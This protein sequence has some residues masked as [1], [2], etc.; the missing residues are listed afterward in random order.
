[1]EVLLGGLA[2]RPTFRLV[3]DGSTLPVSSYTHQVRVGGVALDEVGDLTQIVDLVA[4]GATVVMQSLQRT[5]PPL[6]D[7][8]RDLEVAIG[9]PVQANAYLSPGIG[10]GGLGQHAD[11][12]DVIVLQIAGSKAWDVEGLGPLVLEPGDVLYLPAGTSHHARAESG[13]SLH[14]TIGI[15]CVTRRQVLRRIVDDLGDEFDQPLPFGF[16][17]DEYLLVGALSE[18]T[19]A[20][21]RALADVDVG[22]LATREANRATHRRRRPSGGRLRTLVDEAALG[23]DVVLRRRCAVDITELDDDRLEVRFGGRRLQMPASAR[24]AMD[25]VCSRLTLRVDELDGLDQPS[26]VVLARRLVREGLVDVQ[27][28]LEG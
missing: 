20:A 10:A 22:A 3:Q 19:D 8:C 16:P 27:T 7:F 25:V 11:T 12:H 21:V 2:R 14:L 1:M 26:Q 5:W 24:S 23:A 9:H 13:F 18:T 6:D 28:G 15:L 4:G 17:D